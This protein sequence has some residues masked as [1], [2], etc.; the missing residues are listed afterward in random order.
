MQLN[1]DPEW[2]RKAAEEEANLPMGVYVPLTL[3]CPACKK[4]G[5]ADNWAISESPRMACCPNCRAWLSIR[6]IISGKISK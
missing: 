2:L 5:L 1:N 3:S 4:A 6:E